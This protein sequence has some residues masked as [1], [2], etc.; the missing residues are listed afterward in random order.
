M[1]AAVGDAGLEMVLGELA[2]IRDL[3]ASGLR[4]SPLWADCRGVC[5]CML[6]CAARVDLFPALDDS[7]WSGNASW[8]PEDDLAA[9]VTSLE[10]VHAQPLRS[11]RRYGDLIHR[12]FGPKPL[13][14]VR[15]ASAATSRGATRPSATTVHAA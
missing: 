13:S 2:T 15:C 8:G 7:E 4:G 10:I 5:L 9:E 12:V 1:V 3:T 14:R 6:I 11:S